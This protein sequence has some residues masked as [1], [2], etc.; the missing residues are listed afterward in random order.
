MYSPT[1]KYRSC[2]FRATR[3]VVVGLGAVGLLAEWFGGLGLSRLGN[4]SGMY[5]CMYVHTLAKPRLPRDPTDG[6]E[7]LSR[8]I[9]DSGSREAN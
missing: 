1:R 7:V 5:V 2:R 4:Q 6:A 3:L 8:D 9:R